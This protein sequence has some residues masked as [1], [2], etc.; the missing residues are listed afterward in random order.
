VED[1]YPDAAVRQGLLKRVRSIAFVDM[2]ERS[3]YQRSSCVRV[4]TEGMRQTLLARGV[5]DHKIV[6]VPNFADTDF[7]HPLPRNNAF[8]DKYCL[9]DAFIVL[10]AGNMSFFHGLEN[11]VRAAYLVQDNPDL[12]FVMVGEGRARS[13][14]EALAGEL[15]VRNVR[16]LPFQPREL[17]PLVLA[18]SDV[19]L[20]TL[21]SDLINEAVPSKF[22]W[23]LA[24]GRPLI[25]SV[26]P[27]NEVATLVERARCG[28]TVKA[29]SPE[30]IAEAVLDLR[31]HPHKLASMGERG[32][33]FVV[34]NYSRQAVSHQFHR[35]VQRV[36]L[37]QCIL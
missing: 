30:A 14:L 7:V 24:S 4:L 19:S 9:G 37:G 28:I 10:Y 34:N 32:R 12:L 31:R 2:V 16:F 35:L 29:D 20:V 27:D 23:L 13:S 26:H 25:A 11:V 36:A 3:C 17:V 1:I 22:Y 8:R 15:G 18:S 5:P 33:A 21:K 6:T